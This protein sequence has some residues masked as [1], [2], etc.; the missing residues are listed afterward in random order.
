MKILIIILFILIIPFSFAGNIEYKINENEVIVSINYD[1]SEFN[2][3]EFPL[4]MNIQEFNNISFVKYI[5]DSFIQKSGNDYF[6][7][8]SNNFHI[9]SHVE[10]I[11]PTG[12]VIDSKYFIFPKNYEITTNG[13]NIIISWD[14]STEKEILIAYAFPSKFNIWLVI[15]S[16]VIF[17]LILYIIK[18]IG[19][20]KNNYTKNLFGDEKKIV[21]YL[22]TKKECWTKEIVRD[23]NISKVKLSRKLRSLE[24]KG[25]IKKLPYGNENRIIL[26]K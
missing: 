5:T 22:I 16:L 2:N 24:Q 20:E 10:V 23:L 21:K 6:F 17:F 3:I 18:S 14:N 11:L 13:Q 7:I 15:L 4:E 26:N 9:N 19:A 8:S 1:N 25:L 12:A